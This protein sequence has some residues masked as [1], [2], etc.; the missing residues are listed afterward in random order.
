MK[1][2]LLTVAALALAG[3]SYGQGLITFAHFA[4]GKEIKAPNGANADASVT[5][6]L[7]VTGN[8]TALATTTIFQNTGLFQFDGSDVVVPGTPANSTANLTVRAWATSA[9]SFAN[10]Q[11]S[12]AA[13]GE[14]SFTSLP[15]GGQNPTPPPPAL[16]A[17]DLTNFQGFTMVPEP[18]TYALGALAVGALL[19]RRRK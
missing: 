5:V 18:T 8:N 14:G 19:L 3:S 10:A 16:T 7:Y 1:K 13:W 15:L 17:P 9:G 6:G 11:S 4:S 12:G 2:A